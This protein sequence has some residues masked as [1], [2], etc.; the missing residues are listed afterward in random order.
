[1]RKRVFALALAMALGC[2]LLAGC[3]SGFDPNEKPLT[4]GLS[5]EEPIEIDYDK[6]P[7]ACTI[8]TGAGMSAVSIP[9]DSIVEAPD[10]EV[11]EVPLE[12]GKT[13]EPVFTTT[14]VARVQEAADAEIHYDGNTALNLSTTNE[15]GVL[16]LYHLEDTDLVVA[17]CDNPYEDAARY[18]TEVTFDESVTELG[19]GTLRGFE[20]PIKVTLPGSIDNIDEECV[21]IGTHISEFE[22]VGESDTLKVIDNA[23]YLY[24]E[25][26]GGWALVRY[27]TASTASTW[28]LPDE[29]DVVYIYTEAFAWND[30]LEEV[31]ISASPDI[32][33]GYNVF[34]AI[35]ALYVVM[36]GDTD[37][38]YVYDHAGCNFKYFTIGMKKT[39][40]EELG[41]ATLEPDF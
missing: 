21:S 27:A 7:D 26:L 30:Y 28:S 41:I 22:I 29:I 39:N 38:Y 24:R 40:C 4:G 18:V 5:D 34:A 32:E 9:D 15:E 19:P 12:P 36:D 35:P 33:L 25:D 37:P 8:Y 6:A 14:E 31:D 17:N 23:L 20:Q 3:N 2:S 10:G 16:D 13:Y 1:M 11:P